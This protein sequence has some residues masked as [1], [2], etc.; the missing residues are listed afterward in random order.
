MIK[1]MIFVGLMLAFG[2]AGF[3]ACGAPH[4]E[5]ADG[6]SLSSAVLAASS[7]DVH[8]VPDDA[9]GE[10]L[11]AA[12]D[13][14]IL[15]LRADGTFVS[16]TMTDMCSDSG[17]VTM[18]E[19]VTGRYTETQKGVCTLEIETFSFKAEGMEDNPDEIEAYVDLLAGADAEMRDMY[20]RLFGGETIDGAEFYGKEQ[21]DA[22]L[23]TEVAVTFDFENGTFAYQN[24]NNQ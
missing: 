2:A 20:E 19:T 13:G 16:F 1:K 23:N 6:G 3:V 18:I 4:I 24:T 22:L 9:I 14:K 15:K 17:S 5:N 21:F 10:Y 8:S 7:E 12:G 11:S